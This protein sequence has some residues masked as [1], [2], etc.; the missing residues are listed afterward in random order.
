MNKTIEIDYEDG[1]GIERIEFKGKVTLKRLNFSEKN[2]LEEESSD[3]RVFGNVP[4]VKVSTSKMKELALL[5]S[6][7]SSDLRKITFVEDRVTK[8]FNPIVTSYELNIANIKELP[9]DIGEE[10]FMAFT[11][12]NTI[13][14][15]K[16]VK[17]S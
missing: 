3:I 9:Q 14:E 7:V 13:S 5:K 6:I 17:L 16:K 2:M 1:E 4:Q 11:E 8:A 10:L 12:I 15:K